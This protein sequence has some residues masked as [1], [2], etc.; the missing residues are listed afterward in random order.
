MTLLVINNAAW[1]I[2][3]VVACLFD[4]R[5]DREVRQ[6][7]FRERADLLLRIQHPDKALV[8]V[9]PSNER[10]LDDAV[11]EDDETGMVGQILPWEK[12][13]G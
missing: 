12:N 3:L 4:A 13:D 2:A 6:E 8:P 9:N 5:R 11:P 1:L 7:A 10:F